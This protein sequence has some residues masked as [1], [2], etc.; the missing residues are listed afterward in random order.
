MTT[1]DGYRRVSLDQSR[2]REMLH[3]DAFAF[4]FTVPAKDEGFL[5]TVVPWERAR[6]LEVADASR[7]KVG[8]LAATHASFE[9]SMRV[10]GGAEVPTS[11]LTWVG[12]HPG[13]RRRGLLRDMIA[14]HFE[15]SLARGEHISVLI[16]AETEI[17]QRFGYGLATVDVQ[18]D[19]GRGVGLR[20]LPEADSLTV[21]IDTAS[22]SE[23]GPIISQVQSQMTRPGMLTRF[24]SHTLEDLFT[25]LEVDREGAEQLR[26]VVIRDG[27]T[28]V[29][30]AL[31]QRKQDWG[32]TGA[33]GRTRVRVWGAL[34]AAA[35]QRLFTV[36][37]DFDL[38]TSTGVGGF[39]PDDP[40]ILRLKDVRGAKLAIKDKLWLRVLDVPAALEARAYSADCDVTVAITDEQLPN[41][42]G[43]WRIRVSEGRASVERADAPA[44]VTLG[45]QELGAAY[46]GGTTVAQL[47]A[48]A[49]VTE[50]KDGAAREL[51]RA[52][53]SDVT[54]ASNLW[55]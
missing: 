44:D 27:D 34:T 30:W 28:P 38:M 1:P 55:F 19:L 18:M 54:P 12:V 25:D 40:L 7:G 37:C 16:A 29:A 14:D 53:A 5:D 39:A 45:A 8:T 11:G 51:S 50:H 49:L 52:F 35:T 21:E 10:P 13:H 46:L 6:A 43:T 36:L 47:H 42:A 3:I 33:S 17:Y 41:N 22:V 24:A 20:E 23:H 2:S 9:F 26:I 15:R 32:A 4:A 31:F 48:A